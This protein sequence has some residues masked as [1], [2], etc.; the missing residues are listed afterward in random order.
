MGG[1]IVGADCGG[2]AVT[3]CRTR[4]RG[5][6]S[7]IV[8]AMGFEKGYSVWAGVESYVIE[9]L[10]GRLDWREGCKQSIPF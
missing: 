9:V 10:V 7:S 2:T 6:R 4:D 5:A 3:R 1:G 8:G